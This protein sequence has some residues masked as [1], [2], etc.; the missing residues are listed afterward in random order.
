M[1]SVLVTGVTGFLGSHI[2]EALCESG[3]SVIGL[4]RPDSNTWRCEQF[5]SNMYWIDIDEDGEWA[6]K[7]I[8]KSPDF[9]IHCAWIGVEA[10]DRNNW[11]L[12]AENVKFMI[13]L[14]GIAKTVSIR[15]FVFLGS[16]AEYGTIN[17]IVSESSP[18]L[19]NSAYGCI[20]LA[21]LEILKTFSSLNSIDWIWL[22]VF[23][24]FGERENENWLIP[25]FIKKMAQDVEMDFT[26]G[27]QRYAYLYVGD[28]AR[29]VRKIIAKDIKP[30]I[31]NV[32]AHQTVRLK[33]LIKSIRDK[34]NPLFKLNFGALPYRDGQ[35]LHIEGDTSKLSSE[36][37]D[38]ELTNFELALHRTINYY[39]SE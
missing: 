21:L 19:A 32:S 20:K 10:K 28:F 11:G 35:S 18:A 8:E 30:G 13:D 15:K 31:Y 17:G 12:Q 1:L 26:S 27:E 4:K 7:I 23:S 6:S 39:L 33:D 14:L 16:Q 5:T 29:I 25:S 38:F 36:L 22:R 9:I 37:G 2:A 24:I 3:M 34:V